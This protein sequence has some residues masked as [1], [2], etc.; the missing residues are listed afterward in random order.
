MAEQENAEAIRPAF[1]SGRVKRIM[2]LDKDINKVHSE[3]LFLVSCSTELFLQF[4]SEKSAE[5]AIEKKRKTVKL[6]HIR[7]AAKR[8]QPT[9]DF[10]IDS[11]LVPSQTSDRPSTERL[12][13]RP[14]P[15]KPIPAGTRRIDDFFCKSA[16]A[17]PGELNQ[18]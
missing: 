4:M 18:E 15:D 2:K 3:A 7:T 1:P 13:S 5:I 17:T 9:G 14:A 10:L 12:T 6:E 8:H 11:L 16:G